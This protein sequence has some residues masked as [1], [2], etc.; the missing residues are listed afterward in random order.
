[1]PNGNHNCALAL[2][3]VM[4][5]NCFFESLNKLLS[6]KYLSLSSAF[7]VLH[8]PRKVMNV[9]PVFGRI[10]KFWNPTGSCLEG[11]AEWLLLFDLLDLQ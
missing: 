1:M 5:N 2:G 9:S 4:E 8:R 10:A 3:N 11:K 6:R 7:Q